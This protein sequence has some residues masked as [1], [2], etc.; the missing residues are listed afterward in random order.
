MIRRPP[1][2][3]RTDTLFPYTTL[4]RSDAARNERTSA[5]NASSSSVKSRFISRGLGLRDGRRR[6][7]LEQRHHRRRLL[8][9]HQ[10]RDRG[11]A[12]RRCQDILR[13]AAEFGDRLLARQRIFGI[14]AGRRADR[15]MFAAVHKPARQNVFLTALIVPPIVMDA[16][17]NLA[18]LRGKRSVVGIGRASGRDRGWQYG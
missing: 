6:D 10:N 18:A 12:N 14:A 11:V 13:T 9:I 1:I 5:R 2:S 3:T 17:P 16:P 15:A 7:H 4:F 8:E